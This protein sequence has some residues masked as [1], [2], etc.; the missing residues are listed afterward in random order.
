LKLLKVVPISKR[1]ER[2]VLRVIE[3]NRRV[4]REK[5]IG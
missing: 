5:E 1:I 3:R 4:N 2:I